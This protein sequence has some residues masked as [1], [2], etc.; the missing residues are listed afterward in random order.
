MNLKI[1]DIESVITNP[2]VGLPDDVF[3]LISRMTPLINVDLLIKN[4][5]NETL[6]TWRDD[7]YY[8][9]G[10]HIPGGIIRFKE[11]I[12]NRI[13]AC[14]L[15]ELGADVKFKKIPLA[16]NE[17]IHP[18]RKNRGHFL[19]LLFECS[20]ISP[21]DEN[22]RYKRGIPNPGEWAWHGTCP[23]NIVAVH[24]MYREFIGKSERGRDLWG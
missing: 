12:E 8:P 5:Q 7:G 13:H 21:P 19:S 3:L 9:P 1:E 6:L 15:N 4:E 24:E 22:L 20:L 17:F 2:S 11:T 18:S 16:I 10:W 14:A 23:N